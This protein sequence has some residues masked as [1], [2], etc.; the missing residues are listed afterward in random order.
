MITGSPQALN[1]TKQYAIVTTTI[2][3]P[4]ALRAY[5]Q[6][7][8]EHN[9]SD[10]LFVVSRF[11]FI[12]ENGA[13]SLFCVGY[14]RQENSRRGKNILR[15]LSI[16]LGLMAKVV[17][18]FEFGVFRIVRIFPKSLGSNVSFRPWTTKS[19]GLSAFQS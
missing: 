10:V 17:P 6:N 15:G 12:A 11:F 14:R 19:L 18:R 7:A 5:M 9:K 16:D 4:K 2:Y 1:M 13:S 3:V 8:K